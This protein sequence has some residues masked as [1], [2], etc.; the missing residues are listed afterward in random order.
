MF[1]LNHQREILCVSEIIYS[2][3]YAWYCHP[4]VLLM[5]KILCVRIF[6]MQLF[7]NIKD[8]YMYVTLTLARVIDTNF[9]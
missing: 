6:Y 3:R 9:K 4:I 2:C 7:L 8:S 5:S 1:E